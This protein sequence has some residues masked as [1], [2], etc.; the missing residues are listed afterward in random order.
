MSGKKVRV[1]IP[2]RGGFQRGSGKNI[3]DLAG[4]PFLFLGIE[5][6]KESKDFD[7]IYGSSGDVKN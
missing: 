7:E 6:A 5:D 2:A 1:I 4:K 3:L